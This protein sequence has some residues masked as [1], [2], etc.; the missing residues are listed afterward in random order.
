MAWNSSFVNVE[1]NQVAIRDRGWNTLNY[2][3]LDSDDIKLTMTDSAARHYE[4][5]YKVDSQRDV[6][7]TGG[8]A[9]TIVRSAST[10]TR[11]ISELSGPNLNYDP[12][13]LSVNKP[14]EEVSF[15]TKINFQSGHSQRVLKSLVHH[16]DF[17][18]A[19]E[20]IRENKAKG[21]AMK[22]KS[23]EIKKPT[24]MYNF[25]NIGCRIG[26]DSLELKQLISDDKLS[27]KQLTDLIN[28]KKS[29]D[30]T[31]NTARMKKAQLKPLWDQLKD[32]PNPTFQS[33][34]DMNDTD[35]PTA[36][37]TLPEHQQTLLDEAEISLPTL[38]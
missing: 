3:L 4:S 35:M 30:D 31:F 32:R 6:M 9:N 13:F 5:I 7:G 29:K 37:T 10:S 1:N 18:Q 2:A 20:S 36:N 14:I 16:H 27:N 24:A 15:S 21:D 34:N 8:S 38:V 25:K 28:F 26:K 33:T 23:S 12:K 22:K 11:T 17:N 19:R